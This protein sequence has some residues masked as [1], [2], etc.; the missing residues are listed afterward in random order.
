MRNDNC[1]A[2]CMPRFGYKVFTAEC[3]TNEPTSQW[4]VVP[5]DGEDWEVELIEASMIIFHRSDQSD[6]TWKVGTSNFTATPYWGSTVLDQTNRWHVRF[7][8]EY[9]F[10]YRD[11]ALV[12]LGEI[13]YRGADSRW[14]MVDGVLHRFWPGGT[15]PTSGGFFYVRLRN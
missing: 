14:F 12:A 13:M 5:P 2:C 4:G 10:T 8:F 15:V 3:T 7:D 9:E 1:F 6:E 11:V